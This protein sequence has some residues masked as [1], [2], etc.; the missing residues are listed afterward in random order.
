MLQGKYLSS[1]KDEIILSSGGKAVLRGLAPGEKT[2]DAVTFEQ[3]QSSGGNTFE[4]ATL[5][6]SADGLTGSGTVNGDA[7][8]VSYNS[9]TKVMTFT[10]AKKLKLW[11]GTG[12]ETAGLP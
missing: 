3:L 11:Q 6:L 4:N 10:T 5:T 2:G 8:K 1:R 9:G 12:Y 7:T